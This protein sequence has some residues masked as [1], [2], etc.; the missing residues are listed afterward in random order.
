MDAEK[1]AMKESGIQNLFCLFLEA[2]K[3]SP[4]RLVI[5]A[6]IHQIIHTG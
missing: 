1:L 5:S 6:V 4:A 2:G 3:E